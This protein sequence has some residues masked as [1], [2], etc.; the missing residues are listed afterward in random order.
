MYFSQKITLTEQRYDV[1]DREMLGIAR[2]CLKW[3][4]YLQYTRSIVYTDH[5]PLIYL[6]DNPCLNDR[7]ARWMHK[8]SVLQ[9]EFRY[10]P[11]L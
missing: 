3:R 9:L 10:V 4:C 7:Q 2:Y 6:T 8:L 1:G 11:G 5:K